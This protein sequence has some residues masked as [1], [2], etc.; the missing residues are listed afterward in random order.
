MAEGKIRALLHNAGLKY[1]PGR[2]AL[3]ELLLNADHP[4][5]QEEISAKLSED[6]GMNKV[7]I[8]RALEAFTQ[9]GLVHRIESGDRA[10]KFAFCGCGDHNHNHSHPHFVCRN[11]GQVDC[12]KELKLPQLTGKTGAYLV[13]KQEIYLKGICPKCN[14]LNCS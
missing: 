10:W 6:S 11:C 9:V 2:S 5:N 4:L 3:M 1:T 13:E 7:T 8:Y 14:Q 12:L